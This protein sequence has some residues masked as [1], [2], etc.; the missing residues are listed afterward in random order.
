MIKLI[1]VRF[2]KYYYSASCLLLLVGC[3]TAQQNVIQHNYIAG[4]KNKGDLFYNTLLDV[5]IDIPENVSYEDLSKINISTLRKR[6]GN[7]KDIS[8]AKAILS[9]KTN[10]NGSKNYTKRSESLLC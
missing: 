7:Y 5:S 2:H 1:P 4:E 3:K 6:I 8:A 10:Q 9:Y